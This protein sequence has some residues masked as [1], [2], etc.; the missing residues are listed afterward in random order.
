MILQ[1]WRNG[2]GS[3]KSNRGSI[4]GVQDRVE[5]ERVHGQVPGKIK[6]WGFLEKL[7]LPFSQLVIPH[8][9]ILA[10]YLRG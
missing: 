10:L 6:G 7:Q 5:V 2:N 8:Q 4:A 3:Q 9:V 1:G